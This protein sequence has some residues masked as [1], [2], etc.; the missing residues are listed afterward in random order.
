MPMTPTTGFWKLAAIPLFLFFGN[1]A[2]LAAQ[3]A[4][5]LE[6]MPDNVT[7]RVTFLPSVTWNPPQHLTSTAQLTLVVPH[8]GFEIGNV[9][10][11]SGDWAQNSTILAPPENPGFDYFSFGLTG[12]TAAI[13]YQA[14][15]DTPVFTFENTGNCPGKVRLMDASDPFSPPNSQAVNVGCQLTTL[16]AGPGVNAIFSVENIGPVDCLPPVPA[17]PKDTFSINLTAPTDTFCI[18]NGLQIPGGAGQGSICQQGQLVAA[19]FPAGASGC[20]YFNTSTSSGLDTICTVH[21]SDGVC[22]TTIFFIKVDIPQP[23]S[24]AVDTVFLKNPTGC[25]RSDGSLEISG[26]GA[27]SLLF[28]LDGNCQPSPVFNGLK[29]GGHQVLIKNAAQPGCFSTAK[30]V[31]LSDPPPPLISQIL[32]ENPTGCDSTNGKI[33]IAASANWPVGSLFFS[34]NNGL[35]WQPS[36][37]FAGQGGGGFNILVKNDSTDCAAVWPH[38]PVLLVPQGNCC[39]KLSAV[40]D[41]T[42]LSCENQVDYCLELVAGTDAAALKFWV[43]GQLVAPIGDCG[44]L[45]KSLKINGFGVK[46]IYLLDASTGCADT[47]R[48]VRPACGTTDTVRI[49]VA[50]GP[51]VF[52]LQG[53]TTVANWSFCQP[54]SGGQVVELAGG[55]FEYQPDSTFTGDDAF[56]LQICPA[57]GPCNT[58]MV[59]VVNSQNWSVP[60]ARA[61]SLTIPFGDDAELFFLQNDLF[62]GNYSVNF[63]QLPQVGTVTG[64]PPT[65]RYTYHFPQDQ[66][67]R[68][69]LYDMFEYAVCNQF[70]CDTAIISVF[71][72]C[73]PARVEIFNG[74]SPNGDGTNDHFAIRGIEF[75][76]GNH[77]RVLNRWGTEVFSTSDYD[78]GWDGSFDGRPLP[79]GVYFYLL[80]APGGRRW[81]GYLVIQP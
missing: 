81:K 11:L 20:V 44:I 9:Q 22:D 77:L 40:A 12:A 49:D 14:G 29:A 71:V 24:V 18:G 69:G 36:P 78:G 32:T 13:A 59:M 15:V 19:S 37:E 28:C 4:A 46:N 10:S 51:P 54:P 62:S 30:T 25:G 72:D 58:L 41:Q 79:A 3:V 64:G 5:R 56:C 75:L 68:E 7:Y 35:N 1:P 6:L 38:N 80:D 21:C 16:G 45:G 23:C 27:A 48:L 73:D 47:L 66:P 50:D 42:L 39:P 63:T 55:C 61:D 2:R 76:K 52:C 60:V 53:A 43:N 8:A 65:W 74:F 33:T 67:C 70:G 26:S 34:I 57:A 17:P 31:Q